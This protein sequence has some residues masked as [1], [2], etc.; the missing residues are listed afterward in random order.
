MLKSLFHQ[1][2]PYKFCC[3][4]AKDRNII[5]KKAMFFSN[6]ED[7]NHLC[8][9]LNKD[10]LRNLRQYSNDIFEQIISNTK[11]AGTRSATRRIFVVP[12]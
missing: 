5:D 10:T 2:T 12:A 8:V 11:T 7:I 9:I 3:K 6:N 4:I 1:R